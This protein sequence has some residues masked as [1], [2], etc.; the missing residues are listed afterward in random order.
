[1]DFPA[2]SFWWVAAGIAVSGQTLTFTLAAVGDV[3]QFRPRM[4]STDPNFVAVAKLLQDADATVGNFEG[5]LVDFDTF[6]G[7]ARGFVGTEEVGRDLRLMGF[8]LLNRANNHARDSEWEGHF[9][10]NRILEEAGI[11]PVGSGRTLAEAR[12]PRYAEVPKGRIG[13]VGM[14][15]MN[16]N[17]AVF[18]ATD[19][20]GI[21]AARPGISALR[22]APTIQVTQAQMDA[23]KAVRTG[24]NESVGK[25]PDSVLARRTGRTIKASACT[26]PSRST[27]P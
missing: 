27:S 4:Q 3:S 1:M 23:L 13:M 25:V 19:Q 18:L 21:T 20:N 5:S 11:G 17:A 26:P 15:S 7:S 12:A 14:H 16:A 22:V 10:T 24:L 8:D 6:D 9:A 2:S